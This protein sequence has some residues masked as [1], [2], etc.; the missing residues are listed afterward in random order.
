MQKFIVEAGVAI[1]GGK[2]LIKARKEDQTRIKDLTTLAKEITKKSGN[3]CTLKLSKETIDSIG[4][5]IVLAD[6]ESIT[7][8]NTFEARLEQNRRGIRTKVA[9]ALFG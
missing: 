1:G 7:I 2:L 5:V 6:D 4:G 9:K 8:D 3:K